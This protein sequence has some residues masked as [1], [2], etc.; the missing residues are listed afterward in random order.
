[1]RVYEE[2]KNPKEKRQAQKGAKRGK[3]TGK[4]RGYAFIFDE[5]GSFI[6]SGTPCY[7]GLAPL[8]ETEQG[9][10]LKEC[11]LACTNIAHEYL[12]ENCRRVGIKHLPADWKSKA[13][14]CKSGE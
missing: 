4:A 2:Y 9:A 12:R 5:N 8:M 3:P 1:M 6:S 13:I 7:E 10:S 11:P 14:E